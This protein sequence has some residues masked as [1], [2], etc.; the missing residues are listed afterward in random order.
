MA[1][2]Q[3]ESDSQLQPHV[4]AT[5][6]SL[7][8][9][10]TSIADTTT[11]DPSG[12]HLGQRASG[13]PPPTANE[14]AVKIDNSSETDGQ[15]GA[16]SASGSAHASSSLAA[17][18]S[19]GTQSR[20]EGGSGTHLTT[21]QPGQRETAKVVSSHTNTSSEASSPSPDPHSSTKQGNGATFS[22]SVLAA[23]SPYASSSGESSSAPS[24]AASASIEDISDADSDSKMPI[25]AGAKAA[26]GKER[27]FDAAEA[28]PDLYGL[29][30]SG[31]APKKTYVDG[32]DSSDDEESVDLASRHNASM[33]PR[34]TGKGR[35]SAIASGS[36]RSA[37]ST[38]LTSGLSSADEAAGS[39]DDEDDDDDDDDFAT[40]ARAKQALQASRKKA[41]ARKKKITVKV[42]SSS[43]Q[44]N[45]SP[46]DSFEAARISSRTGKRV[47]Y[48]EDSFVGGETS[49][50]DDDPFEDR[51]DREMME[52]QTANGAD[53]DEMTI[54]QVCGHEL[55]EGLPEDTEER[56]KENLRFII[57]WKNY[58]H[59]HNTA[60]L[61]SFL[62]GCKGFKRVE[63]YVRNIWQPAHT[64]LNDPRTTRE[65][66]E[67]IR[68]DQER[69]KE[70]LES[71]KVIERIVAQRDNPPTK[72]KPYSHLAYLCK[73]KGLSYAECTWEADDEIRKIGKNAI[74]GYIA[75]ASSGMQP[76]RSQNYGANRPKYVRMSEQ[77]A[78]LSDGGQLKEFQLTGLNW[79]AYLWSQSESGIL[80][81]EM[82]LGKTVQ[83]VS[84]ISYLVHTMHQYGPHLVVV[85][86]STLPAWIEQFENWAPDLNVVAYIGNTE[87]RAMI[88]E[89]EFGTPRK[90]KFN[91]L[92]TT[93]EYI[94][95]DA[96]EL[97][98]IKWQ[99][100]AVDEA[101]RLKNSAAQLYEVLMGFN[102]AGKLLITGTPLQNNIKELMALMH[103]LRPDQFS[104]DVDF[105]VTTADPEAVAALHKKL[106]NVMIRRLKKDV[107]KELPGKTEKILRVEMSAMQQKMYKAILSRN[108]AT[109][110]AAGAAQ[111]SLL[112]IAI[113]LKKVS[114]HPYLFDGSETAKTDRGEVLKGLIMNSGKM[115]LLDKLLTRLKKD[116][117]RVLIFSQMVRMLDILS[118]YMTMRGYV[119]QRLDGMVSSD[120]RR[121][122]I[123][124]FNAEGSPDFAFL[125]STRAGGL[126]IN[127]ETADTVIIFD[128]DWNPQ[129]DLQA[130]ARAH[131]LNSKRH[132]NVYRLLTKDTVE[133]DV[134]ERAKRKMVLEYA[135]IHQMDTSGT[136]FAPKD[137]RNAGKDKGPSKEDL[138]AALK[139]GAKS[140]FKQTG[141]GDQQQQEKLERLD[142]DALLADAEAHET[143]GEAVG[144]ASGGEAFLKQFAQVQD[145]K[146]DDMSWDDIMGQ[147]EVARIKQEE[148]AAQEQAVL[149]ALAVSSSRRKAAQVSADAYKGPGRAGVKA[150][151]GD[152]DAAVDSDAGSDPGASRKRSGRG[153]GP[154]GKSKSAAERAANLSDR[155]IRVLIRCIQR[156][157][158]IHYRYDEIVK[159]SK[160]D[161]KNRAVLLQISDELI[162]TCEKGIK[163]HAD[164]IK[165]RIERGEE[166]ASFRQK[167]VLVDFRGIKGLNAETIVH[168]HYGL[169]LLAQ[170]MRE[171]VEDPMEF[172]LPFET[173]GTSG[174]H[175]EWGTEDDNRL[176]IGAYLYGL[177]GWEEVEEDA[178]LHMKGKFFL[179]EGK[180]QAPGAAGK[181]AN[182][183]DEAQPP[184]PPGSTGNGKGKPIPNAV[185]LSRRIDYLLGCL[186]EWKHPEKKE[187]ANQNA[188]LE[189]AQSAAASMKGAP[190]AAKAAA[191]GAAAGV[192]KRKGKK[193]S[194]S[195]GS[196]APANAKAAK[197]PPI[198]RQRAG[199]EDPSEDSDYDFGG[200]DEAECKELMRPCK[201][202]LRRLKNDTEQ[203]KGPEKLAALKECLAAIGTRIHEILDGIPDEGGA[204]RDKLDRHLWH[205]VTFFWPSEN[206]RGSKIKSI[207]EKLTAVSGAGDT[208]ASSNL[209]TNQGESPA[210]TTAL[211]RKASRDSVAASAKGS[212]SFKKP[213]TPSDT[214]S[215]SAVGTPDDSGAGENAKDRTSSPSH[216]HGHNAQSHT[217]GHGSRLKVEGSGTPLAA[218]DGY[219]RER[220]QWRGSR[221]TSAA[222][223]RS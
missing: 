91:V 6:T 68:V 104:L 18:P 93:Y 7:S 118:D 11:A 137:A 211:K 208:S 221:S 166:I 52:W 50:Y 36:R 113:E 115:V 122:A 41:K 102:V 174:W 33:K 2:V 168:R 202:H 184:A 139:F 107:I 217:N 90:L 206:V 44:R 119:H 128:S 214:A 47:T 124:R 57:K 200:T 212:K 66:I 109:L 21:T 83:S 92:V 220:D 54:E 149:D 117:H 191:G 94:L 175:C 35:V 160:L 100:L 209:S 96:D 182:E 27:A 213:R 37:A 181:T 63:N 186:D 82:G 5:S 108:Y 190:A 134:I 110:S 106:D 79:L 74:D 48:K 150:E 3:I 121:K 155:D 162:E 116:G 62:K 95:K 156:W 161:R 67:A 22:T 89:H 164:F 187:Q 144:A 147:E 65:D 73:W 29:R 135:I 193:R 19:L 114:N 97:Q 125:L 198:K 159:E 165:G 169:R 40:T 132:V 53:E 163:D 180:Y 177:G 43:R 189:A 87:A 192:P 101:H 14:S 218:H 38:P 216:G 103:F 4:N 24:R 8:A 23:A 153:A 152:D 30:R 197:A 98:A 45:D 77:P 99:F 16:A 126:G 111:V 76:A 199:V 10:A 13:P 131:R 201:R 140:M 39:A 56:P 64:I 185:H 215:L 158:D 130:M 172:H 167:A 188:V 25:K 17:P 178:R 84:F 136:N 51:V 60:E 46:A 194:P 142:I 138:E 88:R 183:D 145:F 75:R 203:L 146:A 143:D 222:T 49:D 210:E 70:A 204:K 196:P 31:R 61:W 127:L 133:E 195:L 141:E 78:Y 173:K 58:S 72:E 42:G 69:H 154:G 170:V 9:A 80:A 129:N 219:E 1:E 148:A 59:L 112:N 157:G 28:N 34:A 71:Y 123:E 171:D 32:G 223:T 86:L 176:L 12:P 81:D 15:A 55:E 205:F 105:D 120:N 20:E 85:P 26:S 207:Y 151:G 179:E